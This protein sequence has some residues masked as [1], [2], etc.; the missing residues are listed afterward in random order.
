[1]TTMSNHAFAI[2]K[3]NSWV[4]S[5]TEAH[6]PLTM[7][8]LLVTR[9]LNV[10]NVG[11]PLPPELQGHAK[12]QPLDILVDLV[13]WKILDEGQVQDAIKHLLELIVANKPISAFTHAAPWENM[14]APDKEKILL[15]VFQTIWCLDLPET[16]PI[17]IQ[18]LR[19]RKSYDLNSINSSDRRNFNE[20]LFTLY[21]RQ[22]S[23]DADLGKFWSDILNNGHEDYWRNAFL[24]F[25]DQDP[26]RALAELPRLVLRNFPGLD[27]TLF[28]LWHKTT[29]DIPEKLT[30]LLKVG[31]AAGDFWAALAINALGYRLSHSSEKQKLLT[32]LREVSFNK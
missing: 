24:G 2:L 12:P 15:N 20:G 21:V 11:P 19:K 23:P 22:S 4:I 3:Q 8:S 18:W 17:L 14:Y 27:A 16:I 32:A 7:M 25:A 9:I 1:M 26:D 10:A 28:S 29:T 31:L 13:A 5:L 6:S 30:K